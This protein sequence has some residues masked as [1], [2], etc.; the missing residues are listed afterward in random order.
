MSRFENNVIIQIKTKKIKFKNYLYKIEIKNFFKC[1][2]EY[3]KQI[4]YHTLLNCFEFKKFKKK[5]MIKK[6]RNK[7]QKIFKNFRINYQNNQ[8]F[9]CH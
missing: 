3:K 9:V 7:F 4:I 6:T 5:N 1:L 8:I 2:C